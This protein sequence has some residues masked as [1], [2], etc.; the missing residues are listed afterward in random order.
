MYPLL[1]AD[2]VFVAA[3]VIPLAA[4]VYESIAIPVG[5]E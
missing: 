2:V 5:A 1:E 4:Q 3:K